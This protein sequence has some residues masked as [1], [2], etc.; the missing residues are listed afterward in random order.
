MRGQNFE[1][2]QQCRKINQGGVLDVGG[3]AD[4]FPYGCTSRQ[5]RGPRANRA[6][7]LAAHLRIHDLRHSLASA[8]ANARTPLYEIGALL[9]YR[10]LSTTARHAPE[11]LVETSAAVARAWNL[12]PAPAI[13]QDRQRQWRGAAEAAPLSF[14]HRREDR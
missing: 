11:R 8:R 5:S 1:S 7:G 9:G 12:P 3:Q 2:G 6:A 10:H 14:L 13:G 4:V